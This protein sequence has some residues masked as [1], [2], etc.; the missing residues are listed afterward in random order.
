MAYTCPKPEDFKG[1]V[2]DNGQCVRF[3]QHAAKAP[4]TG[5][6]KK[7]QDIKKGLPGPPKGTAIA[8]FTA[9]KYQNNPTGNHA[10]IYVS[11]DLVGIKVWDQWVG[12]AVAERIIR[13]EHKQKHVSA[14]NDG[15]RFSVID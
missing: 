13:F 6:W 9:G 7:G 4:N 1:K 15:N 11:Q 2:V 10:A 12:H 5:L 3:V 14:S 8:T